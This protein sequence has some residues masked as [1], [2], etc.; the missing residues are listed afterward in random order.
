M[1][2]AHTVTGE[3]Y[4]E[5]FPHYSLLFL[6]WLTHCGTLKFKGWYQEGHQ[7]IQESSIKTV[8]RQNESNYQ[9]KEGKKIM[10]FKINRYMKQI[11]VLTQIATKDYGSS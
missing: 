1:R 8:E 5:T 10:I 4:F 6:T 9:A 7:K 11:N 3:P 2:L